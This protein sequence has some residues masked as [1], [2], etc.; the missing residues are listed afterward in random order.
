MN[1][2]F[3]KMLGYESAQELFKADLATQ[4]FRH[5]A[6]YERMN[7]L[8]AESKVMQGIELEWKRPDGEPIVVR[9][10]GHRLDG[11]DGG[12]DYFEVFAE[13][14]T[15]R[16]TLERQ[17]RM[18][19]KMEAIG[20]LSGGIAH[21][22]NNLLGVIIGYSG[23]LKKSLD[24]NAPT[25]E[26]ATEIEKAGQRAASLTRQLLAF[27]RQQVL[28][29]SVLSLNS[30]VADMEKMLPRLLGEDIN[31]SLSLDAGLGNVKADQ[32]QIEQVIM[33]LAVNARD[34][35]PSGGKLQIQTANVEFD[36]AYTR[37]HPGSKIGS[38]V[39]LA[40]AD[41]GTGM[42]AETLAHIFEPFFTTKG[43]G[44]GTGLG[45][46]TVYGVVKQSNGYIWVDSAPGMG[47]KFQIYLPRH[48][49]A[50]QDPV[51][52]P[53]A[54]SREKPRG[55]EMILL[56]EDADPLRKLAQAF[57]ESNGFRVL[58]AANG[59]AALEIAGRHSGSF[60]LLLTD[61]VMPGM[62]GRVLAE[63]LSMRQPGLKVLFMSGYTDTFIAGHGVL[64]K[65]T[66]LLHKP[67]TEEIL[68]N[69]VREVLDGAT[70]AL[71]G[72]KTELDAVPSG[73]RSR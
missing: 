70:K 56:V 28:S 42:S 54:E 18:A 6:D 50:E 66:N 22:F 63:Q 15:E 52:K 31:V 35:M 16:R 41:S 4:V 27:S 7:E 2:A 24:K 36:L 26:F 61:V 30:L 58:S 9:C 59:E 43:V 37:D 51:A 38:Y 14:V 23:V 47:A 19:Q 32:S 20:R 25:F 40:I 10:S 29:P 45:L 33:N 71:P 73:S 21:D 55:S 34:A 60:D 72:L 68:I 67:F 53:E 8:L 12:P 49:D 57:L 46:A 65:G 5:S 62:N 13:D 39:M 11:K 48:L 69:K 44:E 64:E 1:P 3:Q 17:L